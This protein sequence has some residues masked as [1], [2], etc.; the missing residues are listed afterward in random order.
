[1]EEPSWIIDQLQ[2]NLNIKLTLDHP[3]Y[4]IGYD[5]FQKS[6]F[7]IS[8]GVY[9]RSY[10]DPDDY[11]YARYHTGA[12]RNY[13]GCSQPQLDSMLEQQR[14]IKDPDQRNALI[15]QI[16]VYFMSNVVCS[17]TMPS[18]TD[19]FPWWPMVKNFTPHISFG[20]GDLTSAWL[21]S[22]SQ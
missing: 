15:K 10:S 6:D 9:A 16:D 17:I 4:A 7:G 13:S 8:Y 14:T 22:S 21:D 12:A 18:T 20:G 19:W 11:L 3:E 2:R 5:R 1:D